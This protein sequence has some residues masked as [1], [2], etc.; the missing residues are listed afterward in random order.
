M[1][2]V[3]LGS[4][5]SPDDE[6]GW[7]LSPP[8]PSPNYSPCVYLTLEDGLQ[9]YTDDPN[10]L[11]RLATMAK[12]AADALRSAMGYASCGVCGALVARTWPVTLTI[13]ERGDCATDMETESVSACKDC[14]GISDDD[15]AV[16]DETINYRGT[17]A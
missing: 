15:I 1:A 11:D 3:H 14:A 16:D 12:S 2:L 6:I 17:A 9:G 4:F 13:D 5:L 10:V 8:T 7:H